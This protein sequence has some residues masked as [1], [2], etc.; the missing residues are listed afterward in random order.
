MKTARDEMERQEN[1]AKE[2]LS[3][4]LSKDKARARARLAYVQTLKV[5][6][7]EIILWPEVSLLSVKSS[8]L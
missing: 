8:Q 1:I 5:L 2:A 6:N 4:K 7:H 3:Q